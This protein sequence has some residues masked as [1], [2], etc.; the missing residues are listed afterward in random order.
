MEKSAEPSSRYE[1]KA[2]TVLEG[3][4]K[5]KKSLLCSAGS[6]LPYTP[7]H[8]AGAGE[9]IRIA[10]IVGGMSKTKRTKY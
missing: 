4:V 6:E 1:N 5:E 9:I 7:T 8:W 2:R 3:G 10:K